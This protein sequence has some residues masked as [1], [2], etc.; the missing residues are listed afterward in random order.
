MG[1]VN[2]KNIIVHI[3]RKKKHSRNSIVMCSCLNKY[4]R[5]QQQSENEEKCKREMVSENSGNNGR[6]KFAG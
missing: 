1:V 6:N 3:E 2:V 4:L 5:G